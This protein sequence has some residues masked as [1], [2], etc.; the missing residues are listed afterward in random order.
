MSRMNLSIFTFQPLINFTQ[1]LLNF[2]I[3]LYFEF[4]GLNSNIISSSYFPTRE[5]PS[6]L[7]VMNLN[8][9]DLYQTNFNSCN[10]LNHDGTVIDFLEIK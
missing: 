7:Y 4:N 6:S 2:D 8:V 5:D 1:F 9:T 3:I 10:Y